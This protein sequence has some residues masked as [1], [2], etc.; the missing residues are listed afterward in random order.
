MRRN[1]QIE[2]RFSVQLPQILQGYEKLSTHN[3]GEDI[4]IGIDEKAETAI[5]LFITL[6][7]PLPRPK[8]LHPQVRT[9]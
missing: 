3:F 5:E 6:S 1:L 2:G 4:I 7:P 9:G 8:I